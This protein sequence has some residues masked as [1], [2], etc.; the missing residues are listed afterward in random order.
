MNGMSSDQFSLKPTNLAILYFN[1][2]RYQTRSRIFTRIN[3][4]SIALHHFRFRARARVLSNIVHWDR[5][6]IF[7]IYSHPEIA[8]HSSVGPYVQCEAYMRRTIVYTLSLLNTLG[9]DGRHMRSSDASR[10]QTTVNSYRWSYSEQYYSLAAV[11][12][13]NGSMISSVDSLYSPN[14]RK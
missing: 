13:P 6:H 4:T 8:T 7:S 12:L 1:P 2:S 10:R 3:S 5:Q 11:V 9:M 14:R